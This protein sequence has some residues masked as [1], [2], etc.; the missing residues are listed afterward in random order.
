MRHKAF[1]TLKFLYFTKECRVFNGLTG[2]RRAK[3]PP[4][5]T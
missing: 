1:R 5:M 3:S 4:I 2:R